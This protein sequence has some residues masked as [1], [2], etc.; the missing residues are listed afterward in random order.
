MKVMI[1]PYTLF[2]RPYQERAFFLKRYPTVSYFPQ[3]LMNYMSSIYYISQ[4]ALAIFKDLL[5]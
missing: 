5:V 4:I 1:I 3:V 2:L